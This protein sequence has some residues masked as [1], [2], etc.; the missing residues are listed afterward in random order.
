MPL[1]R[2]IEHD[3]ADLFLRN[4]A[5]ENRPSGELRTQPSGSLNSLPA[6]S[7]SLI[8]I[9][10]PS[11]VATSRKTHHTIAERSNN[12]FSW[13]IRLGCLMT[14]ASAFPMLSPNLSK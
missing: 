8:A 12:N 5:V 14:Y 4:P 11:V 13:S 3:R 10:N 7:T 9:R 2:S 1:G 6:H